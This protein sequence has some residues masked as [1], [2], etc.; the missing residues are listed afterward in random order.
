MSW[1]FVSAVPA[2]GCDFSSRFVVPTESMAPRIL[3][4]RVIAQDPN[5]PGY[6]PRTGSG[7]AARF[8]LPAIYKALLVIPADQIA[9]PGLLVRPG[10]APISYFFGIRM[11]KELDSLVGRYESALFAANAA[12]QPVEVRNCRAD[13][14]PFAASNDK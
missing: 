11:E 12:S 4:D 5:P 2:R 1:L 13:R 7:N 3:S 8:S 6:S 10:D 14:E 9:P